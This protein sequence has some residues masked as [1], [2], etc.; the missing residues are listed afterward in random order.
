MW[1]F[2]FVMLIADAAESTTDVFK[3]YIN[4]GSLDVF[5]ILVI[6]HVVTERTWPL[7]LM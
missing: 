6:D 4:L 1:K 2:N 3:T 7:I 5:V